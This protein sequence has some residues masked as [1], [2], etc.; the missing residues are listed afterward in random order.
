MLADSIISV[1]VST[2]LSLNGLCN[3]NPNSTPPKATN[4]PTKIA[5]KAEPAALFGF[6]KVRDMVKRML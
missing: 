3:T 6:F 4:K 2:A 1:D 5:G